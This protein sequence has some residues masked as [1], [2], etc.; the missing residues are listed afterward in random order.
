LGKVWSTRAKISPPFRAGNKKVQQLYPSLSRGDLISEVSK[1][2]P[3]ASRELD[4]A[5]QPLDQRLPAV[6]MAPGSPA[7]TMYPSQCLELTAGEQI[8]LGGMREI[9]RAVIYESWRLCRKPIPQYAGDQSLLYGLI[10]CSPKSFV[11]DLFRS[12]T[13]AIGR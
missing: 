8:R 11:F 5:L 12:N 13:H 4:S 9:S 7:S 3:H 2:L 1:T 6:R 10:G